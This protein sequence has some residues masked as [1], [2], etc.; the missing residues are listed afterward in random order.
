M[1]NKH[2]DYCSQVAIC[3]LSLC[4]T[5]TAQVSNEDRIQFH[6]RL[7]SMKPAYDTNSGV[8]NRFHAISGANGHIMFYNE[9]A[10]LPDSTILLDTLSDLDDVRCIR[11]LTNKTYIGMSFNS[12]S[13][14][15]TRIVNGTILLGDGSYDTCGAGIAVIIVQQPV[16]NG[17]SLL[18]MV[19][20]TSILPALQ[21]FNIE[22]FSGHP[23]ALPNTTS[24]QHG[25]YANEGR[26]LLGSPVSSGPY[27]G[28]ASTTSTEYFLQSTTTDL[29]HQSFN[30]GPFTV[31]GDLKVESL[32]YSYIKL[33]SDDVLG[34][35]GIRNPAAD[36]CTFVLGTDGCNLPFSVT[37]YGDVTVVPT[38]ALSLNATASQGSYTQSLV[39]GLQPTLLSGGVSILGVGLPITLGFFYGLQ[40]VY[41]YQFN[42]NFSAFASSSV[43]INFQFSS[44]GGWATSLQTPVVQFTHSPTFAVTGD[45]FVGLNVQLA[46]GIMA[47][48]TVLNHL[49]LDFELYIEAQYTHGIH[50]NV[51]ASNS[52]ITPAS[53]KIVTFIQNQGAALG[54]GALFTTPQ[55][56]LTAY[57]SCNVNHVAELSFYHFH[58][59]LGLSWTF[60]AQ[61]TVENLPIGDGTYGPSHPNQAIGYVAADSSNVDDVLLAGW[62]IQAGPVASPPPSPPLPP[63][64]PPSPPSPLPPMPP[65]SPP[66]PPAPPPSP[67]PAISSVTAQPSFSVSGCS[68][69]M[70]INFCGSFYQIVTGGL[71]GQSCI[72]TGAVYEIGQV[73]G[74]SQIVLYANKN[75]SDWTF[76]TTPL[77]EACSSSAFCYGYPTSFNGTISSLQTVSAWNCWINNTWTPVPLSLTWPSPPPPSPPPL[78]PPSPP[79]SPPPNPPSPPPPSPPPPSPPPPSPLPPSPPLAANSV[80]TQL[81]LGT[82]NLAT[83]STSTVASSVASVAG[84]SAS[85]VTVVVT[86]LPVST[87]FTL[88]SSGA[89]IST[90]GVSVAM[91]A[92]LPAGTSIAVGTPSSGRRKLL[93]SITVPVTV[94]GLGSST[95]VAQTVS[96]ALQ[97]SSMATAVGSA[98]SSTATASTPTVSAV[99]QVTVATSSTSAAAAASTALTSSSALSTALV[100]S[101]QTTTP[102]TV[103]T[104]P[105][106]GPSSPTPTPTGSP[107]TS[108]PSSSGGSSNN[109]AVIAGAA[110]GGGGGLVVIVVVAVVFFF[111]KR[112]ASTAAPAATVPQIVVVTGTPVA[113]TGTD[114]VANPVYVPAQ[115]PATSSDVDLEA[116]LRKNG[117]EEIAPALKKAGA[118]SVDDVKLLK[119]SDLEKLGV[120]VIQRRKLLALV[121][122]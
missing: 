79:P 90:T 105:V 37:A 67:P 44:N 75:Y 120:P 24:W 39:S 101:G 58:R 78:P 57:A 100:A 9:T 16:I 3:L 49:A 19:N 62:C 55:A 60:V 59:Y 103:I 72:S 13:G 36:G 22:Y 10:T 77:L 93:T 122:E 71:V 45:G 102:I 40:A 64:L 54:N 53:S 32:G 108:S 47:T 115:A 88:T 33:V 30:Y 48:P 27:N 117:L 82:I 42:S 107:A 68:Q 15:I 56:A 63:P 35:P 114:P 106:T 84:V 69:S 28:Q 110:G 85:S 83:F 5:A 46:F 74:T 41:S 118:S 34:Q 109:V 4:V 113:S 65:P 111:R 98:T 92:L 50:G 121:T 96:T 99:L 1:L 76:T 61:A 66:L 26:R 73:N 14:N 70:P 86:D 51:A 7:G 52:G 8:Y 21:T 25:S 11:D 97:S 6:Q 119:E 29:Y 112:P 95:S 2:I 31:T 12:S 18:A 94:S 87:T 104:P 23:S 80:S 20:P 43:P 38:L 91:A 17:S 89:T 116:W 81:Q